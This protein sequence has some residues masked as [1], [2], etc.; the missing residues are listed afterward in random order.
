M[1]NSRSVRFDSPESLSPPHV[2]T[3]PSSDY[4]IETTVL[5]ML[6]AQARKGTS[7][8]LITARRDLVSDRIEEL[9]DQ[10]RLRPNFFYTRSSSHQRDKSPVHFKRKAV[11]EILDFSPEIEHVA[12][13]EDTQEN[14][15]TVKD[16]TRRRRI[17]F[18][19][20]LVKADRPRG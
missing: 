16:V 8:A 2:P 9:L 5:A 7:V 1:P 10:K 12:I 20:H 14:V 17:S 13:W 19:S 11:L 6:E 4:W 3:R 18:E 15:D